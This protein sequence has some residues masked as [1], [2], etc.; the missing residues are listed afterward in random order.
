MAWGESTFSR[1]RMFPWSSTPSWQVSRQ[2]ATT[3]SM[4]PVSYTH[5][6]VYKRQPYELSFDENGNLF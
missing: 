5:L 2:R 1:Y 4:T 6:D 3:S